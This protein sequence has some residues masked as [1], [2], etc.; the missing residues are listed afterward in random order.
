MAGKR[1][2]AAGHGGR[3]AGQV[4]GLDGKGCV[5][6]GKKIL[7]VKWGVKFHAEAQ[8]RKGM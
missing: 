6:A 2:E 5:V 7:P 3:I 1:R 4:F 8:R